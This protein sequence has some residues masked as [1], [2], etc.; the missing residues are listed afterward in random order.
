VIVKPTAY[1]LATNLVIGTTRRTYHL[2][3]LSPA[4]PAGS[5]HHR[6]YHRHVSFYY[7]AQMVERWTTRERLREEEQRIERE[8]TVTDLAAPRLTS[9]N[10]DYK[11]RRG[12][13]RRAR[14][15]P[16]TVFDD[17][18]RTYLRLPESARTGDLP[19]LL[20]ERA[21]GELGIVNYRVQDGWYVVDGTFERAKLVVGVG[22]KQRSVEIVNRGL[23]GA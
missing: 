11:V 15:A 21:G 22:K 19:A 6:A 3:L 16:S 23:R 2:R 18:E 20:V 4:E 5:G 1:D 10:F 17:G 7:P 13:F 14:F 9:L 8:A 12:W